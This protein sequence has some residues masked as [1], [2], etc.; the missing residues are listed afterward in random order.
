MTSIPDGCHEFTYAVVE[1][2]ALE[3]EPEFSDS[4]NAREVVSLL[5]FESHDEELSQAAVKA[6]SDALQDFYNVK[7]KSTRS[8]LLTYMV[9]ATERLYPEMRR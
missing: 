7:H 2:E 5:H 6:F 8:E 3:L 4:K 9:D 1:D